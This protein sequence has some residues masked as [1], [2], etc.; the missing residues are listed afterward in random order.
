MSARDFLD[1]IEPIFTKGG[2]IP[3]ATCHKGIS[4]G[5][6]SVYSIE[7]TRKPSFT[8]WPRTVANKTS[9]TPPTANVTI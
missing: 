8:S 4:G 2:K 7:E 5:K 1:S 3:S 9:Q 6:I